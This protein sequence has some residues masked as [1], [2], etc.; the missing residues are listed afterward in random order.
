MDLNDSYSQVRGHVLLKQMPPLPKVFSMVLQEKHQCKITN[1]FTFVE[2]YYVTEINSI[3]ATLA[4]TKFKGSRPQCTR[5][6]RH[7]HIID[8]FY[9]PHQRSIATTFYY[10]EFSVVAR[11]LCQ[12]GFF[13]V[14]INSL[15]TNSFLI[16]NPFVTL[17]AGES[18]S[19]DR[20]GSI[21]ISHALIISN[22]LY[23]PKF[24]FNLLFISTLTWNMVSLF[25]FILTCVQSRILQMGRLLGQVDAIP[26]SIFYKIL[27]SLPSLLL[28]LNACSH[29][30]L[31]QLWHNRL[32]HPSLARL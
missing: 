13:L 12:N 9:K 3:S 27:I 7:G 11:F 28:M 8:K 26:T 18:T 1:R 30:S 23:V 19:V 2:S 31:S 22:V 6:N 25:N 14:L 16:S 21:Y 20:I 24:H 32:G 5:Y 10:F 29:V 15:F 4:V 17:P